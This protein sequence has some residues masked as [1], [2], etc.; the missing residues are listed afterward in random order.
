[1]KIQIKTL[2][3]SAIKNMKGD[4]WYEDMHDYM[5]GGEN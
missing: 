1:M 2:T 3:D 4:R 5:L